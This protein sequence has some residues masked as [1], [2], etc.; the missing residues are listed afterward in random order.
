MAAVARH[1]GDSPESGGHRLHSAG[2]PSGTRSRAPPAPV[3]PPPDA[4]RSGPGD[5]LRLRG[6][7]ARSAGTALALRPPPRPPARPAAAR[8]RPRD[9]PV[10]RLAS[11]RRAAL[12]GATVPG[13]GPMRGDT[14]NFQ[15]AGPAGLLG[16]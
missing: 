3:T 16:R 11:A 13:A 1:G 14:R 15:S 10:G 9:V 5:G 8:G 6:T 12:S 2:P 7:A 4:A